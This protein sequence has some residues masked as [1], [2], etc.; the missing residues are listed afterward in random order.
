MSLVKI[1]PRRTWCNN[2]IPQIKLKW[3]LHYYH[4][5]SFKKLVLLNLDGC[6]YDAV[7]SWY[8]TVDTKF[9][10][11]TR[12][13]FMYIICFSLNLLFKFTSAL[14]G[15]MVM[16]SF[17]IMN[18]DV[19]D[20]SIVTGFVKNFQQALHDHWTV[21]LSF[22][23]TSCLAKKVWLVLRFLSAVQSIWALSSKRKVNFKKLI[24]D[25]IQYDI[26]HTS[27]STTG[28]SHPFFTDRML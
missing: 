8:C 23:I 11:Y 24:P 27:R 15:I 9:F 26:R 10:T 21:P 12:N 16:I 14:P 5:N 13:N 4:P 18:R 28:I 22:M 1:H 20:A 6:Q 3:P 25:N 7:T 19:L 17:L 2:T